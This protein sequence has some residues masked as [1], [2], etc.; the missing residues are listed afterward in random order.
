MSD[1]QTGTAT[2]DYIIDVPSTRLGFVVRHAK[3]AKVRGRFTDF[4]G[5]AHVDLQQPWKS[6]ASVSI[7]AGS[8]VT[9]LR[10]RD[11]Y[12][13]S[14]RFL[15]V[16]RD[17]RIAFQSADVTRTGGRSL[18]VT[19]DL[20]MRGVSKPISIDFT[21]SMV[22]A[23]SPDRARLTF[24]GSTVLDRRDWG[25]AWPALL[26]T[27]GIL[28]APEVALELQICIVRLAST[29]TRRETGR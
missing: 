18:R 26:E 28:V 22:Q 20:I 8:I 9:G 17:P 7:D 21:Y 19:G 10:L 13:R 14:S 29:S 6:R 12:L 4:E 5:Y 11:A 1:T 27:G 25:V 23:D 2:G 16:P 24:S 3:V 15:S